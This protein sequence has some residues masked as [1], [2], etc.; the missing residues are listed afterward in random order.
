MY[1]FFKKVINIT[2]NLKNNKLHIL[3]TDTIYGLCGIATNYYVIEEIYN[4]KKRDEKKALTIFPESIEKI[5][6][7]VFLNTLSREL[8][9]NFF[10]GTLTLVLRKKNNKKISPNISRN[11]FLGIRSP[12][13]PLIQNILQKLNAPMAA[14]SVN[15]S[16]EPDINDSEELKKFAYKHSINLILEENQKISQPS[17]IL[18]IDGNKYEF[19]RYYPESD[20][21]KQIMNILHKYKKDN[22]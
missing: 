5:E 1:F 4:I 11:E 16:G 19:L 2:N 13:H 18:K 22:C 21:Y 12:N 10:P 9:Q 17:T 15:C 20:L 14:T 6:Q 7:Y 3:P 8:I